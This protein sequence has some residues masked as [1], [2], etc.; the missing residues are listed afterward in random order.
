MQH[1]W[2]K[3]TLGHGET[4][5]SRCFITNREAAVLG[6]SNDCDVPPPAPA[7]AVNDNVDHDPCDDDDECP[8]CGGEGFTFDC[9]DGCCADAHV[10]CDDCTRTCDCQKRQ[11]SPELQEVLREALEKSAEAGSCLTNGEF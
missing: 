6:R 7:A 4:M 8:N 3:S 5:C 9:F 2:V 11:A 1:D 10:G